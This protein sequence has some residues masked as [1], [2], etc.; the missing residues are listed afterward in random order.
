MKRIGYIFE[1]TISIENLRAAHFDGKDAIKKK[2][3]WKRKNRMRRALAWEADIENNLARLH[4]MLEAGTYHPGEYR[5][6]I[7]LEA[8]K[9]REI[10]YTT[11]WD[12]QVV[13][14][15]IMRT[16]G[17][18]L[19]KS[20]IPETYASMKGRG[21]HRAIRHICRLLASMPFPDR[22]WGYQSDFKK[23]YASIKHER[24]KRRTR[25]KIKDARML[26]LLYIFINSFPCKKYLLEHPGSEGRGIPI[27]N[28]VS[29]LFANFFL[30]EFDHW[31]K[32]V[33]KATGYFRYADDILAIFQT[34][35][36]G[37]D[38]RTAI[39]KFAV[40]LD[41]T[42]KP[43]EKLYPLWARR[44]DFLGYLISPFSVK[45]R[46]SNERKFRRCARR[47]ADNLTKKLVQSLSSRWGWIKHISK[48]GRFWF[49]VLPKSIYQI[50][51]EASQC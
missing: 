47:C 30:D 27:G 35:D 6:K 20:M 28:V 12:D 40:D 38:F 51:Q 16:L 4:A 48:P 17:A 9:W 22:L 41:L 43:S 19:E 24:L 26:N 15:A 32:E 10:W 37:R 8:G 44:I 14:R 25:S 49:S 21:P 11:D 2:P 45:L 3:V 46:K 13:Q 7:V 42:I 5:K 34:K 39:H 31:A 18:R 1:E 36:E 50:N 23:Y 29:P 33:F